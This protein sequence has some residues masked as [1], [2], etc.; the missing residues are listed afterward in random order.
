MSE[1]TSSA[2]LPNIDS[3]TQMVRI[4]LV[5]DCKSDVD[6]VERLLEDVRVDCFY[7]IVDVPRL[8]DAFRMIDKELFDLIM[9]DLNLMD[10]DGVAAVAALHAQKPELPIVV[11]SGLDDTKMREKAMVC[12]AIDYLVK[13]K[14]TGVNLK[15]II[16]SIA[17]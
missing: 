15:H 13:G 10:I 8:A 7:E 11:Y 16:E 1:A 3:R 5:E 2:R 9:L 12:G 6:L 17:A 14:A 4:L